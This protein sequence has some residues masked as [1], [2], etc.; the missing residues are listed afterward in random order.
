MTPNRPISKVRN[1]YRVYGR[2]DISGVTT[3]FENEDGY[4]FFAMGATVPVNAGA[5]YLRGCLFLH[6]DGALG[7]S[8]YINEGSVTSCDFNA[9]ESAA[10]TITAVLGGDYLLG[11]AT[12]GT[13]TLEVGM[14]FYNDTGGQLNAG[15]LV[16]L[17]GFDGVN[18][19]T[20]VKADADTNTPATHVVVADT[21]N[22]AEGEIKPVAVIAGFDTS[23]LSVNDLLYL[24]NATS[25]GGYRTT[26]LTGADQV[27]QVVGIVQTV[28]VATG[29]IVFIPGLDQIL[30]YGTSFL[31]DGS[32][33]AEKASTGLKTD[34]VTV[35]LMGT[36]GVATFPFN[37][38]TETEQAAALAVIDDGGVQALLSVAAGEAGYTSDYQLFP[39]IELENDA[40]YFGGDAP[41]GVLVFDIATAATYGADSLAWEYWNGASWTALT[42]VWDQT[43]LTANNGLRSFQADGAVIFSAPT[44]W[45]STTVN[46][47]DVYWVRARVV[48]GFNITQIPIT[49]S[50]EHKFVTCATASEMPSRG[51]IG[52]GRLSWV[53]ASGAN[54]DT[55]VILVNLTKGTCS[56]L[57]TLTKALVAQE[58]DNF[59]VTCDPG[60]QIALYCTQ[61]D[62]TIEFANGVMELN[63]VKS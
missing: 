15:A 36:M 16:R 17:A 12:E 55:I 21:A 31:Q 10:S 11:D 39:D 27:S 40:V 1:G 29:T 13:A 2:Q 7:D 28:H 20:V 60:D 8:L 57:T 58:V 56:A 48:A 4:I 34:L 63:V 54:N 37:V 51:T 41:F 42:I 23:L 62:G 33:D 22:A 14:A 44:D 52:R 43:D 3:I 35:G 30:K 32:V 38:E 6:T 50:V 18:G 24:D 61:E 5:G 9:S 19:V 47:Q 25:A 45:A 49:N 26:A 59:A 46:T 53:T